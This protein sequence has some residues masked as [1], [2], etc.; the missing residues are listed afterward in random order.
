MQKFII[1]ATVHPNP[2]SG[3]NYPDP[4]LLD[5]NSFS[6]VAHLP[7]PNNLIAG[8]VILAIVMGVFFYRKSKQTAQK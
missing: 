1:L 3:R 2:E 8:L 6:P 5:P 4:F 7:E